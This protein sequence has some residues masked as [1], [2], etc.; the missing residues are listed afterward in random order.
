MCVV[1]NDLKVRWVK[2]FYKKK[3]WKNFDIYNIYT[4]NGIFL[5]LCINMETFWDFSSQKRSPFDWVFKEIQYLS[6]KS[7]K[8]LRIKF[9]PCFVMNWCESCFPDINKK[10]ISHSRKVKQVRCGVKGRNNNENYH[11]R[12]RNYYLHSSQVNEFM[13]QILR[14]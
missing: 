8:F 9:L 1:L 10:K 3:E 4:Q 13:L 5:W 11:C 7:N 6:D 12:E 2:Y 14:S